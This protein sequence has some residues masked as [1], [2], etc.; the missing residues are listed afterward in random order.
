MFGAMLPIEAD[1]EGE[2]WLYVRQLPVYYVTSP[3]SVCACL[4]M[5]DDKAKIPQPNVNRSIVEG[6]AINRC[7]AG[8]DAWKCE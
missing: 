1:E 6:D 2:G 3:S 5:R 4:V 7:K 8:T